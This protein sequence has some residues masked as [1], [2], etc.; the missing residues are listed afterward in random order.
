MT[1]EGRC[2]GEEADLCRSPQEEGALVVEGLLNIT[3]GLRRPIRLQ[4]QDD[5]EPAHLSPAAWTP[6]QPS[7]HP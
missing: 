7:C 2:S 6:G 5:R 1:S 3:W 4:I